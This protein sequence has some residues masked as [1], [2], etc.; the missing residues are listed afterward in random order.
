MKH[1]LTCRGLHAL[2]PLF[3]AGLT[4]LAST[5]SPAQALPGAGT[6]LQQVQP[7]L[8]P[9]PPRNRQGLTLEAPAE[10]ALPSSTPFIVKRLRIA[11]NVR[12][13]AQ[14]LHALVADAEGRT[15][16]LSDLGDLARRITRHY[17]A[18]GYPL[19]RAIVPPQTLDEAG[20]V[21]LQVIEARYGRITVDN[22]ARVRTSLLDDT[23]AAVQ[24]GQAIE[25]AGLDRALLLLTD[26]PG[27][28]VQATVRPGSAVGTADLQVSATPTAAVAGEAVADSY[29]S[30]YTGRLR[31]GGSISVFG[32]LQQGDV[33]SANLLASGRGMNYARLGYELLLNG[34]GTRAGAS[35]S[36]LRYALGEAQAPLGAHGMAQVAG[37]S[38]SQPFVR[39]RDLNLS[40]R[41]AL[42]TLRLRDHVDAS[43]IRADRRL[44]SLTL[45]L[46]GDAGAFAGSLAWQG[47]HVGFEDAA[48][49]QA[50]A[51]TV[52]T[53]GS[54]EKWNAALTLQQPLGEG[55]LALSLSGQAARRNLDPSAKMTGAGPGA[56]RAYET[57]ALSGDQG[58]LATAEFRFGLGASDAGQVTGLAFVD[59]AHLTINREPWSAG[60]NTAALRGAGLG[61]QWS[62]GGPVSAR[63]YV[64]APL[65]QRPAQLTGS[66]PARA[67]AEL[68]F[69][70]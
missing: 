69:A 46:S 47:G 55:R 56:V 20:E 66:R 57:G 43:A 41:L 39:G 38:A 2:A 24:P 64:A 63:A 9:L 62:A 5:P 27:L 61:L 67:G 65:G 52:K 49:A 10:A 68:R 34:Q 13:D 29:G 8:P 11:G 14:T 36:T 15:L 60:P 51:A 6:I 58:L 42:E 32:P 19:A 44:R 25:Q 23:L 21:T 1:R 18:N 26:I 50:D 31:L 3:V 12:F 59:L 54:F 30:R 48:A 17:Q 70:S 45:G 4:A 22:Q 37:L 28:L 35:V 33:L 16:R 7:S 53:Q 40:G